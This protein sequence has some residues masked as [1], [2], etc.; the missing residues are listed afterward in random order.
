MSDYII[1]KTLCDDKEIIKKISNSLLDKKLI[2][3]SQI[4]IVESKY[5]WNN[6]LESCKEYL[7][8]M[9]T[10]KK[11]FPEIEKEIKRIHPYEVAEISY[12][13]ISGA[14]REILDWIDEITKA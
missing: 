10:K 2:A 4:S 9:R 14:S 7:L 8:E 1:V 11:L 13:E 12:Y 3:G 5:W 6:E